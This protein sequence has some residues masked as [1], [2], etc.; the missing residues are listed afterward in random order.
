MKNVLLMVSLGLALMVS[1]SGSENL[2]ADSNAEDTTHALNHL[3]DV[4][5]DKG[6]GGE[7][8]SYAEGLIYQ[9]SAATGTA[10]SQLRAV[11]P[12]VL[13]DVLSQLRPYDRDS[14]FD[15]RLVLKRQIIFKALQNSATDADLPDLLASPCAEALWV[16]AARPGWNNNPA[17]TAFLAAQLPTLPANSAEDLTPDWIAN[18]FIPYEYVSG[19]SGRNSMYVQVWMPSQTW[20][21]TV[22]DLARLDNNAA[23]QKRL[24]DAIQRALAIPETRT[25]FFTTALDIVSRSDNQEVIAQAS[26]LLERLNHLGKFP[27]YRISQSIRLLIDSHP[28]LLKN[29]AFDRN[30]LSCLKDT[31][32]YGY[33]NA[34]L[35]A[36]LGDSKAFDDVLSGYFESA[37]PPDRSG[38][39]GSPAYQQ[40][41]NQEIDADLLHTVIYHGSDK[42]MQGIKDHYH[43][44]EFHN[45]QWIVTS[46]DYVSPAQAAANTIS[47]SPSATAPHPAT[48]NPPPP[49]STLS[50]PPPLAAQAN[51]NVSPII[52][53][54]APAIPPPP[55]TTLPARVTITASAPIETF[56]AAGQV[57]TVAMSAVGTTYKV[58]R[59]DGDKL[60]LQD[61]AGTEYRIAAQATAAVPDTGSAAA[62][63]AGPTSN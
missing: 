22:L 23:T 9:S 51:P 62:P 13:L 8:F 52:P 37:P 48:Q 25:I 29:D 43:T 49:R 30:A 61:T 33:Y 3:V 7:S 63:P 60:V 31:S 4:M 39:S 27:Y 28:D 18:D 14:N 26:G 41:M 46:P 47:S 57:T 59:A 58:V 32:E 55:A 11:S 1:A 6:F 35:L 42:R 24:V 56:D 20:E 21:W 54:N 45:G 5:L 16:V 50:S 53:V 34:I 19:M 12:K 36:R 40:G 38:S 15:P 10:A 44:A 17:V 2:T